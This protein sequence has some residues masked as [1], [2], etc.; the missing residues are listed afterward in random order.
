MDALIAE[1]ADR[2]FRDH[3][4]KATLDAAEAGEFPAALW[5][6]FQ[7]A[8][9][10]QTG[11]AESGADLEDLFGVV[12]LA[13]YHAAPLPIAETLLANW[14]L[15]GDGDG[16]MSIAVNGVAPWGRCATLVVHAADGG[17]QTKFKVEQGHNLAGEPRD[18]IVGRHPVGTW[19]DEQG[20]HAMLALSRAALMAGAMTRILEL[21]LGYARERRQ[22]GRPIARFQAVQH[23]LAVLASETAA[24]QRAT[25]GAIE[26]ATE[27]NL[28]F[29]IAAAKARVGEAAGV[30]AEIAHQVHGAMG[31][32][33][34]HTL[35][36]FTRRLWAWRDECGT[37][38]EWQSWLGKRIGG[39]GADA[40]WGAL[41]ALEG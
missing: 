6:A 16:L 38:S 10:H 40:L 39:Q 1:T 19:V 21:A 35:H 5:Q 34:E 41:T 2:I 33:H 27:P 3:C 7:D 14:S 26:C 11:S 8:G 23:G 9:L 37:E 32:T 12:K 13:G 28:L 30:V 18:R 25:D 31:F 17:A 36:H 24:A 29:Q 15:D 20:L 4:D 22:F